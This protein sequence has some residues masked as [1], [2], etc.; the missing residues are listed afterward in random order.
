[1]LDHTAVKRKLGYE[2]T[3]SQSGEGDKKISKLNVYG[4]WLLLFPGFLSMTFNRFLPK[5]F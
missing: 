5:Q 2:M 3:T 1:M 4:P